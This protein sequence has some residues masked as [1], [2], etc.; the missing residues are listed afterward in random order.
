[1]AGMNAGYGSELHLLRMLGRHRAYFDAKVC[2]ATGATAIEWRDFLSGEMR[3]DKEGNVFWDREWQ[4]LNFLP[5]DASAKTAWCRAWP[6]QG[7]GHN[8]D[9]IGEIDLNGSREWL[10][11]EAKA[12]VQELRSSCGAKDKMSLK[13]I[14]RTLD[15]TR[16]AL[17]VPESCDWTKRYYQ[18]CN[19][20]AALHFVNVNGSAARLLFIYFYGDI[21]DE[22]RTCPASVSDWTKALADM[23]AYVTLRADHSLQDRIHKLFIDVRC[24]DWVPRKEKGHEDDPRG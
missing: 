14:Q 24:V 13:R 22:R 18:Y 3:R 10:L 15:N 19:R 6:T 16:T 23:D 11:V 5:D 2:D 12:N 1:M 21:G 8:W 9:A 7:E 17:G 20:L 4:R